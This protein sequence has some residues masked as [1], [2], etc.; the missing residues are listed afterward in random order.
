M[1]FAAPM[2]RAVRAKSKM[3]STGKTQPGV[4]AH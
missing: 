4:A 3:V 2:G 1:R